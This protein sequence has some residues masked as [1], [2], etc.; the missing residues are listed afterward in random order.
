VYACRLNVV[1]INTQLAIVGFHAGISR[2][3]VTTIDHG[4]RPTDSDLG[5]RRSYTVCYDSG[6]VIGGPRAALIKG[7]HI[8]RIVKKFC[9]VR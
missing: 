3:A 7:R 9:C 6:V 2:S 5:L 8:E 1:A 4:D